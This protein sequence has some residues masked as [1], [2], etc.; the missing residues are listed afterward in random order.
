MGDFATCCRISC[1]KIDYFYDFFLGRTVL[2]L[3][4][5]GLLFWSHMINTWNY[6]ICYCYNKNNNRN[7]ILPKRRKTQYS[8]AL[9]SML[10]TYIWT[11]HILFTTI[12]T[13]HRHK[14]SRNILCINDIH[15]YAYVKTAISEQTP[16][17]NTYIRTYIHAFTKPQNTHKKSHTKGRTQNAIKK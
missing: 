2:P 10:S 8:Y 17:N 5:A 15:N 16:R 6:R 13:T 7:K 14:T 11:I 3:R 1:G 4:Q 9:F 12:T